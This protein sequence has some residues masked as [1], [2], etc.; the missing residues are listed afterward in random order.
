MKTGDN[1]YSESNVLI[2]TETEG[3]HLNNWLDWLISI[4]QSGRFEHG[5]KVKLLPIGDIS[6]EDINLEEKY[7]SLHIVIDHGFKPEICIC[8]NNDACRF[9]NRDNNFC[10]NNFL[11]LYIEKN[12]CARPCYGGGETKSE[13]FDQD[14]LKKVKEDYLYFSS[15]FSCEIFN[16]LDNFDPCFGNNPKFYHKCTEDTSNKYLFTNSDRCNKFENIPLS[17]QLMVVQ[18]RRIL[19]KFFSNNQGEFGVDLLIKREAL[20]KCWGENGNLKYHGGIL[21]F[22]SD[23]FHDASKEYNCWSLQSDIFENFKSKTDKNIYETLLPSVFIPVVFEYVKKF[24][25]RKL[26]RVSLVFVDRKKN[27]A[28]NFFYRNIFT[29]NKNYKEEYKFIMRFPTNAENWKEY[30]LDLSA[31]FLERSSKKRIPYTIQFSE[32]KS[33]VFPELSN[34]FKF[35]KIWKVVN[36]HKSEFLNELVKH[37][38]KIRKEVIQFFEKKEKEGK[39]F[40]QYLFDNYFINTD[41]EVQKREIGKLYDSVIVEEEKFLA[42]LLKYLIDEN[43]FSENERKTIKEWKLLS[44]NSKKQ[45]IKLINYFIWQFSCSFENSPIIGSITAIH[46]SIPPDSE[47]PPGGIV[48]IS[49]ESFSE[50]EKAEIQLMIDHLMLPIEHYY[51]KYQYE[52]AFRE[53]EKAKLIPMITHATNLNIASIAA[54]SVKMEQKYEVKLKNIL[55][56]NNPPKNISQIDN[57]IKEITVPL[58]LIHRR[59]SDLERSNNAFLRFSQKVKENSFIKASSSEKK[60]SIN[61][62]FILY[63]ALITVF[64]AYFFRSKTKYIDHAKQIFGNKLSH[65][66]ESWENVV[67][68]CLQL[69]NIEKSYQIIRDWI[70]NE[71]VNNNNPVFSRFELPD[72]SKKLYIIF[73]GNYYQDDVDIF[74]KWLEEMLLNALKGSFLNNNTNK[75]PFIRLECG[76]LDNGQITFL[77]QNG[78]C[79]TNKNANR[80]IGLSII[81]DISQYFF[82]KNMHVEEIPDRAYRI[83][84]NRR[85]DK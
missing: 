19:E 45:I 69:T 27:V 53:S 15:C 33:N 67:I 12:G 10:G 3:I 49:E 17:P 9:Q 34:F 44:N 41:N 72:V 56:S 85:D 35:D 4:N 28:D 78:W 31:E 61:F 58:S 80:N 63:N 29:C 21:K 39:E 2:W 84:I 65:L 32:Q 68:E 1:M 52:I 22:G 40:I 48:I 30:I 43:L 46:V 62:H 6:G 11:L 50:C 54:L 57:L 18:R 23:T 55:M 66:T 7:E 24:K 14:L 64:L 74:T 5:F 37:P 83:S 81:N 59:A 73:P 13:N 82:A 20:N 75:L 42:G 25:N 26:S 36:S 51:L 79:N 8:N 60:N 38:E 70:S 71:L 77:L 16:N 76:K 47:K